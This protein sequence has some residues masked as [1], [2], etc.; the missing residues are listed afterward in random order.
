VFAITLVGPF[1]RCW[2]FCDSDN[3]L[4][5]LKN[6]SL[7]DHFEFYRN[8]GLEENKLDLEKQFAQIKSMPVKALYKGQDLS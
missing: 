5:R 6:N 8:I 2:L 4:I 1:V 7:K 3:K